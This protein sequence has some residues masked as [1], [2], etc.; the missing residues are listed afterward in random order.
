MRMGIHEAVK[1]GSKATVKRL[2]EAGTEVDE[3]ARFKET[4]LHVAATKG[5][6]PIAALLIEHGADVDAKDYQ[7]ATPLHHAAG[8]AA[9]K[10]VKLLLQHGA[11]P[12]ARDT[13]GDTPLH[14]GAG[15]GDA[16]KAAAR[17]ATAKMLI[18]AGSP[19]DAVNLSGQTPLWNAA[20]EGNLAV[21]RTLLAHGADPKIKA[22]GEQ[23]TA[24]D[25]ARTYE[26]ADVVKLLEKQAG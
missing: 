26:H 23:G 16:K 18:A 5:L 21:V 12:A 22:R 24:L 2:L 15:G 25:V 17:A 1:N 10:V 7:G 9:P 3:R 8:V 6:H 13:Y 14:A 19:I 20:S 4:P 11:D